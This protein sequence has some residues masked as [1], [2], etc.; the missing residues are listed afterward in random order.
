[1]QRTRTWLSLAAIT[2]SVAVWSGCGPSKPPVDKKQESGDGKQGHAG[3]DHA[4]DHV[5]G[6]NGGE[7]VELDSK[8]V[9]GED[10]HAE[11]V[12]DD[13]AGKFTVWILDKDIKNELGIEAEVL[14]INVKE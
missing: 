3:H 5:H 2:L 14:S 10:Y 7:V 6:P 13:D 12:T 1:M 9:K 11:W 8:D 4:H